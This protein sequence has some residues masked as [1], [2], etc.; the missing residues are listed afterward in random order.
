MHDLCVST[1]LR[2]W[3]YLGSFLVVYCNKHTYCIQMNLFLHIIRESRKHVVVVSLLIALGFGIFGY[4]TITVGSRVQD[5]SQSG[6]K[7]KVNPVDLHIS[8]YSD[9]HITI[10]AIDSNEKFSRLTL[11]NYLEE[12][13]EV[14]SPFSQVATVSQ[15]VNQ[16]SGKEYGTWLWTPISDITPSYMASIISGAKTDG[17]NA[18]YLSIDPY[19]DIYAMPEGQEKEDA[20][21]TFSATLEDFITLANK[22]GIAVD[23]EAGWR[24]WAE[25]GNQYK[26][27]ATINFVKQFDQT[28]KNTLRGFQFDVE[29]YLLTSYEKNPVPVLQ[30]FL[31]LIDQSIT[32]L[33]ASNLKL[34]VVIPDFYDEDQTLVPAFEYD[35]KTTYVYDHILDVLE[36]RP[37]S[38]VIVMSYRNF[39]DGDDGSIDISQGEVETATNGLYSTEVIV[40]QETGDVQ[41]PYI[42]FNNT[43]KNYLDQQIEK[44]NQA[45]LP[46]SNFGGVAIHYVNAFLSLK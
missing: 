19:L 15:A 16:N 22:N 31:Q 34:S 32:L 21:K 43:S 17:V 27:F 8:Q 36:K 44:I 11:A 39:A 45:F 25:D 18:I 26:A 35:G 23:A 30:N 3:T 12:S 24:N 14:I 13:G 10:N 28:E 37:G 6:P 41:P 40:A 29:P 2:G 9:K 46:Y 20:K 4:G 5:L 38:S 1:N 42:T 7:T 33:G